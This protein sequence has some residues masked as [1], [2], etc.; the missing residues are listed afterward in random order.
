M[1]QSIYPESAAVYLPLGTKGRLHAV[2]VQHGMTA[3]TFMRVAVLDRLKGVDKMLD[4]Q[5]NKDSSQ[6]A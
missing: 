5:D 3:S 1:K 4:V 2:A 6:G